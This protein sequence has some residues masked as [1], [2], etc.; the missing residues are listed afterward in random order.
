MKNRIKK[1]ATLMM[2]ISIMTI[3]ISNIKAIT[4]YAETDGNS[5]PVDLPACITDTRGC[6]GMS[7]NFEIRVTVVDQNQEQ[8]P[9]T[10]SV[11]FLP[12]NAFNHEDYW[13]DGNIQGDGAVW[14]NWDKVDWPEQFHNYVGSTI[15]HGVCGD[16]WASADY[17][18]GETPL[19][20][21]YLGF[22]YEMRQEENFETYSGVRQSFIN[23]ATNIED[24]QI[25][26]EGIEGKINFLD[27]FFKTSGF[28]NY[29][30]NDVWNSTH[31][32]E[33]RNKLAEDK[34]NNREYYI[35]VEPVYTF[36]MEDSDGREHHFS[37]T[38]KQLAQF[39]RNSTDSLWYWPP[40]Y[41]VHM[42]NLF[43]NFVDESDAFSA[44]YN[45]NRNEQWRCGR[46]DNFNFISEVERKIETEQDAAITSCY[47]SYG[48][49]WAK[50]E[51]CA[52]AQRRMWGDGGYI[53]D[54]R[55]KFETQTQYNTNYAKNIYE[56]LADP[57][58]AFGVNV[59]SISETLVNHENITNKCEYN[60]STC[61][62]NNF[63]FESKLSSS[64]GDIF[65]CIYP[66][67]KNK[68][69]RKELQNFSFQSENSDLWCYDDVTYDF[70][71][72]LTFNDINKNPLTPGQLLTVPSGKLNVERTCFSKKANSI[73]EAVDTMLN[74][75]TNLYQDTFTFTFNGEK[76]E[77]KRGMK[78]KDS[79]YKIIPETSLYGEDY[80]KFTSTF[81]YDYDLTEGYNATNASIKISDYNITSSLGS[82]NAIDYKNNYNNNARVIIN[83]QNKTKST[84][85]TNFLSTSN[86]IT[87]T[88]IEKG[89]G[90]AN[91]IYK[92]IPTEEKANEAAYQVR[93][94]QKEITKQF[95]T[96]DS[97]TNIYTIKETTNKYCSFDTNLS[98]MDIGE[99]GPSGAPLN[100]NLKF[101]VISLDYP[102][103]ARD[104]TVR[105]ASKNWINKDENNVNEYIQNNR[106][107]KT[108]EVYNKEPLYRIVLDGPTMIKIR[109]YNK[110][111]SYG[112]LDI[113]CEQGTGRKCISNFLK[114][115]K[116][117]NDITGTCSEVN[118]NNTTNYYSC[119]D[120]TEKSGGRI[121]E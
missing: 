66:S 31:N 99:G 112:N 88:K 89:Y 79:D 73:T 75:D 96:G 91:N 36:Y 72:L 24:L 51:K 8:V 15:S 114:N 18:V 5:Y 76:Y 2:I 32:S 11:Q 74:Y 92:A 97:F 39:A 22:G 37:G 57:G 40:Y 16:Y 34:Q 41:F 105:L 29:L 46:V 77:Y 117:I 83:T 103:P 19:Y 111:H 86:D 12:I 14:A 9:G 50:K 119:A 27:F 113:T 4:V 95:F 7:E 45:L 115:K 58:T 121:D 71:K 68:L 118:S 52:E 1:I 54:N 80:Y 107:V 101:R 110:S 70:S 104:G 28:A 93:E 47:N 56:T 44:D 65:D 98:V 120:K 20:H 42:Y 53:H 6:G 38:A 90:Y 17:C 116:Y 21:I 82:T 13:Y 94:G 59:I 10:R 108:E 23:Y 48:N 63:K 43:C 60:V 3:N 109:E 25:T 64:T 62:D 26:G 78:Y 61:A 33:I 85:T 100:G 35:L 102:F 81:H 106:N 30:G 55:Y 69:P 67:D 87:N 49:D 84:V